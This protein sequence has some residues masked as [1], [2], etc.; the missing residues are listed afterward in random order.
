MLVS[1]W[2][3]IYLFFFGYYKQGFDGFIAG[4]LSSLGNKQFLIGWPQSPSSCPTVMTL[5][6]TIVVVPT[7]QSSDLI[8]LK[9]KPE[10]QYRS[11]SKKLYLCVLVHATVPSTW[12]ARAVWGQSK[13]HGKFKT[14]YSYI[15]R[16]F[17]KQIKKHVTVQLPYDV[18]ITLPSVFT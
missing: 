8:C 3:V 16:F 15:V 2:E 17:L 6:K 18:A 5:N 4:N 1:E 9:I 7:I 14:S 13:I 11:F 12:E 10:N